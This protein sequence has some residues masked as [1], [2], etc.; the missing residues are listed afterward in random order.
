MQVRDTQVVVTLEGELHTRWRRDGRVEEGAAVPG[1]V[2]MCPSGVR[3]DAIHLDGEVRDSIH[4]FLPELSLSETALKEIDVDPDKV[5]LQYGGWFHDALIEQIA[6]QVH[7]EL[8]NPMPGGDMLVETLASALGVHLLRHH[9]NLDSASV[10][11]PAARGALDPRRLQRVKDFIESHL[12]GALSI[13]ALANEAC[14]S[15]YHFSRAF[16]VATGKTPHGYLTDRRIEK[17]KALMAGGRIPLAEIAYRCGFSSQAY[18]TTWFKHAVGTTPGAWRESRPLC[19]RRLYAA[20][21]E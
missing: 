12:D 15:P 11:P 19:I 13:E 17:A 9:S 8:L 18:F 4:L 3:A 1:T 5:S 14:L 2:W 21:Q 6:R 16:K 7:A 10:S 20:E